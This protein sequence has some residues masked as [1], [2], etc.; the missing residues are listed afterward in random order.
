MPHNSS[1]WVNHTIDGGWATDYG[2]THYASP[3]NGSLSIP[4]LKTCEN[5]HFYPD[6]SFGKYPGLAPLI[7]A[8]INAP[9]SSTGFVESSFVRV[10]FDFVRMGTSLTGS[11]IKMAIVGSYLYR[12]TNLVPIQVGDV[13]SGSSGLHTVSTFNDL[14]IIGGPQ[15]P[16][17]WDQTTFQSLAG[18]PPVFYFSTPH[19][20][21]HWAAGV[22]SAP[23]RLYY[24]AVGNPED[25]VGAG[26]G[27]IDI[28]PGD[29][30]GIVGL[31]SWKRELWVFKGP[32]RLSIHRI[33]GSTPSDF[34]RVPFV[35]GIS[36]SGPTAIF[37][38]GDDF[39][40][41]SPR[42]SC[43]SLQTTSN[44]GDYTQAYLN[45]PILSWCRN[46]SNVIN[47][48]NSN[49]WQVV[50]DPSQ[51][52]SYAVLNNHPDNVGSATQRPFVL[53]MDWRFRT[54]TNPYPRFIKLTLHDFTTAVGLTS[55]RFDSTQLFPT[56]GDLRGMII[57]ER[58]PAPDHTVYA[59]ENTIPF[60]HYVETPSLTY[61]PSVYRKTI[62][63]VSVDVVSNFSANNNTTGTLK[64]SYG[65][66]QAPAT[67][68]E[69][70][71][72]G[73]AGLGTFVLG[74]DQLGGGNDIP[75]FT[76]AVSGEAPAFTY[77]LAELGNGNDAGGFDVRVKHFGVLLTPS[78][79]SLE[80]P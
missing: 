7:G 6:G 14:L 74:D 31:L 64:F 40:F 68:I 38:M 43:H 41:W 54:E 67:T 35:Y 22:A 26:S 25:W 5:V 23:S 42:G 9:V 37:P 46:P 24:S 57:Q 58:P 13:E 76:E 62:A 30:D 27:S 59:D 63:A 34:A 12:Y 20:G 52:I 53:M 1:Q 44:Y 3:Q 55:G 80:N 45:F 2:T 29:G 11:R 65:G 61:G 69:F 15:A 66:R 78:S 70:T 39:A 8:P 16:K 33:T 77:T 50:T 17:S 79:E 36:A 71:H 72:A 4:W 28:D 19:A 21:R 75:N 10:V 49:A 56:F 32:N 18:T 60:S 51:N 48:V 47:G 73:G